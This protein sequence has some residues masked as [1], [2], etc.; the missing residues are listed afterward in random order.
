MIFPVKDFAVKHF[1]LRLSHKIAAIGSFGVVGLF[2]FGGL[3]L[4]GNTQQS[5]YQG[6]ANE[7]GSIGRIASRTL[8]G[9]LEA[10]RAEKDFLLRNDEKYVLRH[11]ELSRLIETNLDA[12]HQRLA[13]IGEPELV[14]KA[15]TI[16]QGFDSYS[17]LFATVA[18]VKRTLGLVPT[19]GLEGTLRSSVHAIETKLKEFKD[20]RLEAGMLTMRRHE[21]DFML[22]LDPKYRAEMTRAAAAF[23]TAVAATTVAD[24]DKADIA[25]KLSGYQR[26]IF[27]W[28]DSAERLTV[29]QKLMSESF[30]KIEPIITALGNAIEKID[31]DARDA[32][33][34][35]Q[36][37]TRWQMSV[38][39][40][41]IVPLVLVAI[42][43]VIRSIT[44]P[45]AELVAD[46]GRLAGGD[47]TV[48][49][50]TAERKDE[51]GTLAGAVAKFRDNVIA[52][53]KAAERFTREVGEKEAHNRSMEGV[54]EAFRVSANTLL[55]TVGENASLMNETATAL[56]G[57]AGDA[58]S[59]AVSA[60]GASEETAS[61]VQTVA[62]AAEELSSSIQE[63]GRQVEQATKAVRAAG[64]TTERSATEIEGLSA[65][66]E[67]IG[68]V[69][70]L[71]QA[72]AAQ[73][74]LLALNATI[75]AARAG[76]AG[77][78]FAVVASEVKNLAAET[79]KATEEIAQQVAGIQIS[80]KNA[81]GA[82]KDI[83]TAMRSIDEVTTAIANAVEQ[84]GAA[85]REISSSVQ[86][87]STGTQ[88][89][90]GNIS[91]VNSA[92]GEANRSADQVRTASGTVSSAAE[93]LTEEVRKF[94]IVLRTGPMERRREDDPNFK[95][96]ER[97]AERRGSKA[98]RAA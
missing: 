77:R 6:I 88:R 41:I 13:K 11:G 15:D 81:V 8:M 30:A 55:A 48:R 64:A 23:A 92:I 32:N 91:N 7:S 45:I 85:T 1:S 14:S 96:S 16:R 78:G 20:P 39:M 60:A 57:I 70:G 89:L 65:A 27:A 43:F 22:R 51:I 82:V 29:T 18:E 97:R 94:F 38:A 46:A 5:H 68:A 90:S 10:R 54:V 67:R 25:Q 19:A 83:A 95:G 36:A 2:L 28:M 93:K 37:T 79:A 44:R 73:T 24:V 71:I 59:Q 72:I 80:T 42:I 31:D 63:I 56:T 21:K 47:T 12:L 35:S 52:Q 3:Y 40:L 49:F 69:V 87:A 53:H 17:K 75:E 74:N 66:G 50:A 62:A 86:M 76:D 4:S 84:Q 61:S 98:D 34:K 33:A 9:L 26:D 58:A